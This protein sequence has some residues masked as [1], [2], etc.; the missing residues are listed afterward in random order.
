MAVAKKSPVKKAVR[1]AKKRGGKAPK[2]IRGSGRKQ[3]GPKPP[4]FKAKLD[5]ARVDLL[6]RL[7]FRV[8]QYQDGEPGFD[9][10]YVVDALNALGDKPMGVRSNRNIKTYPPK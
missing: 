9:W 3:G 10:P 1:P 7:A 2:P 6:E 8:M 4:K 5:P